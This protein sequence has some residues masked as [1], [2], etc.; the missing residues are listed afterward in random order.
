MAVD[1]VGADFEVESKSLDKPNRRATIT[2]GIYWNGVKLATLAFTLDANGTL[3]SGDGFAYQ[4]MVLP[5]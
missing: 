4:T 2:A 1:P 5:A 3:K